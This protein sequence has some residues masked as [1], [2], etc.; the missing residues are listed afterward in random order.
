MNEKEKLKRKHPI[1]FLLNDLELE[2]LNK[3]CK[4]YKIK[5]KAKFI[6]ENVMTEIL[7]RF[8]KDYP[9]LFDKHN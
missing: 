8:D 5:N 3:Y 1:T 9:S 7:Y 2:A 6:R 4:K